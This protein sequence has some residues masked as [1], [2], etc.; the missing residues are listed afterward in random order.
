[1]REGRA[2]FENTM[3]YIRIGF[4]SN[5]GNMASMMAASA[6]LPFLPML[7]AQILLNNFLYDLSQTALP[8]DHV[9]KDAVTRPIKWDM[10]S[11]R[12]YMLLFGLVSSVFDI[13]TF[14]ILFKVFNLTDAAFQ[15]GWFIESIATQVLVVYIIRTR[16]MPFVG[17]RPSM[18]LV[19]TSSAVILVAFLLPFSSIGAGIGFTTLSPGILVALIAIVF[20]YLIVAEF[21]KRIYYRIEERR[22][23]PA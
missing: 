20:S 21:A 17:S 9:D 1:V 5:F 19:L 8:T 18:P 12:R 22:V 16:G 13:L 10:G 7:P 23:Q 14:F 6:F 11:I 4:S 3:K 15:T 2:T